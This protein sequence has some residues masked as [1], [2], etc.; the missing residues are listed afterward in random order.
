M[1]RSAKLLLSGQVMLFAAIFVC[2]ALMPRFFF[3]ADQGGMSNYGLHGR[4]IVPFLIGFGGCALLTCAAAAVLPRSTAHYR[5]VAVSLWLIGCFGL[6]L[7]VTTFTYKLS[8]LLNT[9]HIRGAQI[10]AAVEG[11]VGSWYALWLVRDRINYVGYAIL[12]A[13][14]VLGVLTVFG[15]LHVLFTAEFLAS[16]GF[17]IIA[18]HTADMLTKQ[19]S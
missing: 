1:T 17:G 7:A 18:V 19:K 5:A 13:G 11:I 4:T 9:L 3:S 16:L 2:T 10:L 14:L 8:P 15:I 12:L 6:L